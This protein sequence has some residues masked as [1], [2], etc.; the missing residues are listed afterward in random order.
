[1]A[2]GQ[3]RAYVSQKEY[4]RH[5]LEEVLRIP[6][7]V[8]DHYGGS[9]TEPIDVAASLEIKPTTGTFRTLTGAAVAFGLTDGGSGADAI[10]LTDLGRRAVMPTEEGDDEVALREALLGPRVYRDF[11]TQYD[12]KKL[13]PPQIMRNVL[14]KLGVP[15]AGAEKVAE[16]LLVSAEQAKA[17]QTINGDR[18]VRLRLEARSSRTT[19]QRGP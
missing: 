11:L 9:A 6:R 7:V 4:P 3:K 12:N 2:Q 5:T 15:S 13:P 10:G 14:I 19:T 16:Q 8:A 17:L 1:M 18:F